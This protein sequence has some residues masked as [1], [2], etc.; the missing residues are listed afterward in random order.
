MS[1][2]SVILHLDLDCFYAQVERERL[3]LPKDAA[4]AVVQWS[5]TLAVSYPARKYGIKRGS[6][7]DEIRRLAGDSVRIVPVETIGFSDTPP[8]TPR[9]PADVMSREKVSLARYRTASAAVFSA[10]RDVLPASATLERASVDEAFIDVSIEVQRRITNCIPMQTSQT[11]VIVGDR[12]DDSI[13]SNLRLSHGADIAAVLRR[14]VLQ[15]CN[16]TMSAGISINKLL[17]KLASAKN[18]PDQQ[19]IV[20]VVAIL[21][22]MKSVPLRKLRGLGGKLGRLVEERLNVQTAGEATA[23]SMGD[24]QRVCG[25]KASFVYDSVRGIDESEV[26]ERDSSKSFLAAKSFKA[27]MSLMNVERQW[28]PLLAEEL[29][30]RLRQDSEASRRDARTLT[31]SF[32]VRKV[33]GGEAKGSRSVAMPRGSEEGRAKAIGM[34]GLGVLKKVLFEDGKFSFPISFVGLTGTNFVERASE[35]ESLLGHF[36]VVEGAVPTVGGGGN[37]AD[38]EEEYRRRLQERA[39]RDMALRL[40]REESLRG[41]KKP[42]RGRGCTRNRGRGRARSATRQDNGRNVMTVDMFFKAKSRNGN[43]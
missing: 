39:D 17:A 15:R 18:K 41:V 38:K 12:L 27:E 22:M 19:T 29:A 9:P 24:L 23:V 6:T 31:V 10:M 3:N 8:S 33:G 36:A 34:A 32:C 37:V 16:Y 43:K 11:S 25:V 14:N 26:V 5:S 30:H 21:D 2:S 28:M 7:S 13:D 4:I 1:V 40:H 35:R 42:T 20:P